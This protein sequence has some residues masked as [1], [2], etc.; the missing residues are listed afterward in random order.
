MKISGLFCFF[1]QTSVVL[2]I[3]KDH[4]KVSILKFGSSMH[5]AFFK[6]AFESQ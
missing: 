1:V 5:H 6:R 2:A 4:M 3:L